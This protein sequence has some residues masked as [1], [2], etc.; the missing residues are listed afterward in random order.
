MIDTRPVVHAGSA[1]SC[2][3]ADPRCDRVL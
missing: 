2:H 1:R 3:R